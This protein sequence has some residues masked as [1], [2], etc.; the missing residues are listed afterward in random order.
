MEKKKQL[1][2][3]ERKPDL[4]TESVR[5]WKST[6]K[7]SEEIE[8]MA[9][10]EECKIEIKCKNGFRMRLMGFT[11]MHDKQ[12][13]ELLIAYKLKPGENML[14]FYIPENLAEENKKRA[15]VIMDLLRIRAHVQGHEIQDARE[16]AERASDEA[17][18]FAKSHQ[19]M[20][21]K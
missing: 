21:K 20:T 17:R 19:E 9:R 18:I 10:D 12:T 6:R 13:N 15:G 2:Y 5:A 4:E 1:A 8:E 14:L 3:Q 16:F 11:K 7:E